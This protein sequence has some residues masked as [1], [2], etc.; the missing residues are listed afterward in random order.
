MRR[1]S[2]F[3]LDADAGALH[4]VDDGAEVA[5]IGVLQQH[6]AAGHAHAHGIGAGLDA[7]GDDAVLAAL[8]AGDALDAQR[9]G[10]D[11]LD[12]GAHLDE[13]CGDVADLGLGGG[14]LDDGV[15][16]GQH[17]GHEGGMGGADGDLVEHDVGALEA[18]L[19]RAMT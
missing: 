13:A 14:V 8:Q 18:L 12:L 6:V 17:G 7:V 16:L 1:P 2:F 15:A 10:V 9:R 19:G 5:G 11:A 4:H 3:D